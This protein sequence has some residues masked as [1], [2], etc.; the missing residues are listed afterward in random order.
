MTTPLRSRPRLFT[1]S[2]P[3][4]VEHVLARGR[5]YRRNAAQ[6]SP[7]AKDGRPLPMLV[8]TIELLRF[9]AVRE[10]FGR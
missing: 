8:P 2:I 3:D 10:V 1:R 6:W 5:V 9:G 7:L 4:G